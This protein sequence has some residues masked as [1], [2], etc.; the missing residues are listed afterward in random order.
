MTATAEIKSYI[1]ELR[2][3]IEQHERH[4]H[5]LDNPIIP[6]SEFD[7]LVRELLELEEKHPDL[8]TPESPTQRVGGM[9]LVQFD[10]VQHGVPML[11]LDNA[12]SIDQLVKFDERIADRLDVSGAIDF[13]AEPKLDG[14]AISIRYVDGI[15]VTAATRGDGR[16]GEDVTHNIK[17]IG[18][19]PLR[20]QGDSLPAE[21]EIRGEVFMP[22]KGFEALNEAA[23]KAGEKTFA[24]PRNATAG[25]LRQLDPQIAAVRPLTIFAYAVGKVEGYALPQQHSELL[26][27]LAAWGFPV[28][29]ENSVVTGVQGCAEYFERIGVLRDSM[30]YEI[31]GVVF[32]VN[33]LDKQEQLG[34]VSRAPR[35]AIAH[36]FPAQEQ[37]TVVNAV[38]WQVGRTGAVTPVARLE[39]IEVGGVVVSNATLH[40]I[41]ELERKDVRVG[42]TV[43]VRRAGDVIPEVVFVIKAKRGKNTRR[44]KLPKECPVCGSDVSRAEGEAVAR[45]NGGLYCSAQR[46]EALNHF[47]SRRALDIEGLGSKLIDQLV[48]AKILVTP[49]DIFDV[50]KVNEVVLSDLERMGKKSALNVLA[51]IETS[52]D[53]T[54]ARFLYSLGIRE[55]GE[56]TALSLAEHFGGMAQLTAC[57]D[58]ITAQFLKSG[59]LI[60][61]PLEAVSDVGPIVAEHIRAFFSENHNRSVIAHLTGDGGLRIAVEEA[62][63]AAA[64]DLP[65]AA[66]S[67]VVTG[68]LKSMTRDQAKETI[69]ALGGKVTSSV[70]KKTDLLVCGENPGSKLIK[71]EMLGIRVLDEEAF[72]AFLA[73]S[74]VDNN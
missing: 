16:S 41:D 6:D 73:N 43:S 46:K 58:A 21:I 35:W 22:R 70:S 10:S 14:M 4:Y 19:V 18:A 25:S 47:V 69:R 66:Q 17:T 26:S 60:N 37:V 62:P 15:L 32:K 48:E 61:E 36:K 9:P 44:V 33:D 24:N 5:A 2:R 1:E 55:V 11:S 72:S 12:F 45:C 59:E 56:A 13:S 38:D 34:F 7:K 57:V 68:T 29:P 40:N 74:R 54:L 31:D 50:N 42:D 63:E 39:P 23:R 27:Q 8:R 71:A 3:T 64:I 65:F 51:A 67:F 20:L 28:C 49:A 30:P 53:T 52:R